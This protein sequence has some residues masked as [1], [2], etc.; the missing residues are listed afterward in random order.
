[1][2]LEKNG[3]RNRQFVFAMRW[4]LAGMLLLL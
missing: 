2:Y 3:E 1:M 4:K